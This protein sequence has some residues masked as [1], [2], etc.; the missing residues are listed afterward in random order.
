MKSPCPACKISF[1]SLSAFDA[2]RIGTHGVDRHCMTIK[3]MRAIGMTT[4]RL[5]NWVR[6]IAT[7][8]NAESAFKG[9]GVRKYPARTA[10]RQRAG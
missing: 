8:E 9:R 3:E 7:Q 4:N 6:E 2:H 1:N 10:R 5:G